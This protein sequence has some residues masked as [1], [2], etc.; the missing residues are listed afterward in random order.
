MTPITFFWLQF[1]VPAMALSSIYTIF[2]TNLH[3]INPFIGKFINSKQNFKPCSISAKCVSPC[4]L[5]FKL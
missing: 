2:T 3:V 4:L 1:Y 5:D